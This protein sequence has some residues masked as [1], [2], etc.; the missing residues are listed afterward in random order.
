MTWSTRVVVFLL[1]VLST[2]LA[3]GCGETPSAGLE[4]EYCTKDNDCSQE[5]E[6][7]VCE[8]QVCLP[9]SLFDR[10]PQREGLFFA[11]L[12]LGTWEGATSGNLP[13]VGQFITDLSIQLFPYYAV[14]AQSETQLRFGMVDYTA[15]PIV[16]DPDHL[17]TQ[18]PL[19]QMGTTSYYSSDGTL[20][21]P[22][23]Y[24]DQSTIL[25]FYL[26]LMEVELSLSLPDLTYGG[27]PGEVSLTGY[28]RAA[29][30][31]DLWITTNGDSYT[32]FDV[33]RNDPMDVDSDGDEV[34]DA[35]WMRWRGEAIVQ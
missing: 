10:P 35:W 1:L 8:R 34:Y 5:L 31:M 14:H 28:L 11:V 16:L 26:P 12:T 7:M 18:L 30:A 17:V 29:D 9:L 15:D 23:F 32:L 2:F 6:A 20:L 25:E 13:R 27:T 22:V 24:R 19:Q 4:G 3:T 33:L 21:L